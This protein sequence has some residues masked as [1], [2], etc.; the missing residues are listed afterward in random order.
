MNHISVHSSNVKQ[1][2]VREMADRWTDRRMY[3]PHD[4]NRQ[5]CDAIRQYIHLDNNHNTY[6]DAGAL[7]NVNFFQ[8][9]FF[10]RS[11]FKAFS[12]GGH[13]YTSE[14]DVYRHNLMSIDVKIKR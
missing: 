11:I 13:L 14:S 12:S 8:N 1:V 3:T 10:D 7:S 6:S 2:G 9:S 4:D 5:C